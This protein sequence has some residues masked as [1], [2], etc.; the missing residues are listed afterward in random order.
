MAKTKSGTYTTPDN[1]GDEYTTVGLNNNVTMEHDG[2]ENIF[3]NGSVMTLPNE[4]VSALGSS[5]N[6]LPEAEKSANLYDPL[7]ET[8]VRSSF[9]Y[10]TSEVQTIVMGVDT[11][12]MQAAGLPLKRLCQIGTSMHKSFVDKPVQPPELTTVSNHYSG[13][14]WFNIE[15]TRWEFVGTVRDELITDIIEACAAF[16]SGETYGIFGTLTIYGDTMYISR[17]HSNKGFLHGISWER[18]T[19]LMTRLS[20]SDIVLMNST[21]GLSPRENGD[22]GHIKVLIFYEMCVVNRIEVAWH[23]I[24]LVESGTMVKGIR[25]VSSAPQVRA[26]NGGTNLFKIVAYA[27]VTAGSGLAVTTVY[28]KSAKPA[29]AGVESIRTTHDNVKAFTS[30]YYKTINDEYVM[31][32]D[33]DGSITK[34]VLEN[35]ERHARVLGYVESRLGILKLLNKT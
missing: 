16:R 3:L 17:T 19:P 32:D 14:D 7:T 20:G 34:Y 28:G 8:N 9:V 26:A 10:G 21:S 35:A 23:P 2:V 24:N 13:F 25:L 31:K 6:P 33:G 29:K 1:E 22:R 12:S 11:V 30:N 27:A 15:P 4:K 18:Y 5:V